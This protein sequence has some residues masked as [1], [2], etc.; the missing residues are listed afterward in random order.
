MKK[1]QRE[2]QEK[3]DAATKQ[4]VVVVAPASLE[5]PAA[6]STASSSSF[7]CHWVSVSFLS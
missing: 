4:P 6:P 5:A 7:R 3:I 1:G 2:V